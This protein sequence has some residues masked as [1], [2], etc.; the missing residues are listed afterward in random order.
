M[1]TDPIADLL[2][3]IRNAQTARHETTSVPH[4]RLK[5]DMIKLLYEEGYI[6]PYR[7]L[8]KENGRKEIEIT[9]RYSSK[10]EPLIGSLRRSSRPGRRYYLGYRALKPVR[11]GIGLAILST[12][13]GLLTDRQAREEKVG[14]ELLCTIW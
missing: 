10:K 2:T 4:S 1:T 9:L 14:G 5:Q 11:N 6:G 8:E 13:K 3:R 12:P 7:V